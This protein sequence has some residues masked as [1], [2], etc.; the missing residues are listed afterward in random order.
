[1]PKFREVFSGPVFGLV[2]IL[3]YKYPLN[4]S[5][6]TPVVYKYISWKVSQNAQESTCT[7]D[8]AQK[9]SFSIIKDFLSKRDQIRSFLR[10]WSHLLT[11]SLM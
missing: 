8:T 6:R 5:I 9:M 3:L 1:M 4:T 11:K 2:K 10:I 7:I